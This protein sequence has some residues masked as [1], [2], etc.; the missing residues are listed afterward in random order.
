M[1]ASKENVS[2]SISAAF[3]CAQ[4]AAPD[5]EYLNGLRTFLGQHKHGQSLLNEISELK[6]SQ[7]WSTL[8]KAN[9]DVGSLQP[10]P[11]YV[12]VLYNWVVSGDSTPLASARSGVVALPL[13]VIIQI[14]Q[15]LR[16]LEYHN[17]SHQAF[18]ANVQ[19]A[20][21]LQGFCGGLAVSS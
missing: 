2:A 4:A 6:H 8:A 14:S 21:G 13:L 9:A 5:E 7:F 16:Y 15:Y 1:P 18:L 10:G 3:F 12:D 11:E 20:G 17:L 19:E